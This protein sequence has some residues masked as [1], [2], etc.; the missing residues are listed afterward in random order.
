LVGFSI[1]VEP[2]DM[3]LLG[4]VDVRI[5]VKEEPP[6]AALLEHIF[7]EFENAFFSDVPWQDFLH[8][9][10]ALLDLL[11][12]ASNLVQFIGDLRPRA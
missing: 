4:Q 12:P 8:D 6:L 2:D 7:D 9:V 3:L 1:V 5:G 11:R 10:V